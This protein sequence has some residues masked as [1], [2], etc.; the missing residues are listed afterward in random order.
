MIYIRTEISYSACCQ[1]QTSAPHHQS[2]YEIVSIYETD[3]VLI[4][5]FKTRFLVTKH[6][7]SI[8]EHFLI[9]VKEVISYKTCESKE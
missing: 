6:T 3:K 7:T 4:E 8:L 9:V 1:H 5:G 2:K